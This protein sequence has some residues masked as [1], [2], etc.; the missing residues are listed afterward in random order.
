MLTKALLIGAALVAPAFVS[1]ALAGPAS[2]CNAYLGSRN[3]G[4]CLDQPGEAPPP[5]GSPT[6]NWGGPGQGITSSPLFPGQTI[7][8]PLG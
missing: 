6:F 4:I 2:A 3:D 1:L 7:T 5:Q 8:T